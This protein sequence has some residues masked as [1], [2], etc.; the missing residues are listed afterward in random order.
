MVNIDTVYQR[1]LAFANKEQ[2]GYITP[3][4]FNL[5]AN[6][7]Q[8]EIFEQYFY[9]LN[10]VARAPGNDTVYSDIDDMLEE[11][12]QVFEIT[13]GPLDIGTY[14]TVGSSARSL[15]D[16]VYRLHRVEYNNVSCEIMKTKDFNDCRYSGPLVAPTDAR[17]VANVRNNLIR[18]VASGGF[19]IPTG[20][21]YLRKPSKVAWGYFVVNEKALYN[22]NDSI[23]FELHA[24][25]ESELV[26]KILKFA[27][28]SMAKPG[29]TQ[30]AQVLESTQVQQ[31]KQ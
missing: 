7:A 23:D 11:K 16:Y 19:V 31:E 21:F 24:S 15:P 10:Q 6:Q 27:G 25:E 2:R 14:N 20:L 29:V 8:S 4:E 22:T 5:F 28:V 26:Y 13:D 1:V 18:V 9:D 3:Q 12:I 17:P 30:A